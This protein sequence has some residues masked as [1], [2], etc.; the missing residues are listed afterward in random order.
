MEYRAN[1]SLTVV[2]RWVELGVW[3]LN[4]VHTPQKHL[5]KTNTNWPQSYQVFLP[6]NTPINKCDV[7]AHAWCPRTNMGNMDTSPNTVWM[8]IHRRLG[9][10][11]VGLHTKSS[12]IFS[13][14][15]RK[16]R[17]HRH[18]NK[19]LVLPEGSFHLVSCFSSSPVSLFC[20]SVTLVPNFSFSI[21]VPFGLDQTSKQIFSAQKEIKLWT[22][23]QNQIVGSHSRYIWNAPWFQVW[24]SIPVSAGYRKSHDISDALIIRLKRVTMRLSVFVRVGMPSCVRLGSVYYALKKQH[25]YCAVVHTILFWKLLSDPYNHTWA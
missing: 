4:A 1:H 3:F 15:A 21:Y 11:D 25:T 5:H 13:A 16:V 24:L 6:L 17:A 22:G 10:R 14:F 2:P 23:Q 19:R 20:G 18:K 9:C 7:P 8:W 12:F